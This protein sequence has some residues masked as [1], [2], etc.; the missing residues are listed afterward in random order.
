MPAGLWAGLSER[1]QLRWF[2]AAS[3]VAFGL[4]YWVGITGEVLRTAVSPFGIVSLELAGSADA[5][6]RI[7]AAWGEAGR[8]AAAFNIRID[9][10]Y[11]L[12]Y[13]IALSIGC[14]VAATWWGR[15][16][17]RMASLGPA[18]SLAMLL[19]AACD[20]VENVA[21]LL[22]L[23]DPGNGFW[24]ILAR[25]CAM[26][27]FALLPLGLLYVMTG[28]FTRIGTRNQPAAESSRRP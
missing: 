12:A 23:G 17:T 28:A 26:V 6:Q 1:H 25:A 19:A 3:L 7:H 27:K 4:S 11:L 24:P 20:A 15:R 10:L 21:M 22:G 16:S 5:A 13:G 2:G 18:M 14:A 9:F 8:R